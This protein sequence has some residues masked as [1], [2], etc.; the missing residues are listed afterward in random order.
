MLVKDRGCRCVDEIRFCGKGWWFDLKLPWQLL[1]LSH[2]LLPGAGFALHPPRPVLARF[3]ASRYLCWTCDSGQHRVSWITAGQFC[4][5][6]E[7]EF[8]RL[9]PPST[10]SLVISGENCV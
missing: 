2:A 10:A 3:P 1:T 9:V 6:W 5:F 7:F 8:Y 4:V